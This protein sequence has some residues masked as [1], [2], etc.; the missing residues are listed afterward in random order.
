MSEELHYL[1]KYLLQFSRGNSLLGDLEILCRFSA[2]RKN[3][4]ELGTAYGLGAMMLLSDCSGNVTTITALYSPTGASI[5]N[6]GGWVAAVSSATRVT[7]THT[8][9]KYMTDFMAL[10]VNGNDVLT[11][12]IVDVSGISTSNY[13]VYQ[14]LSSGTPIN[15]IISGITAVKA[16]FAG[17]GSGDFYIVYFRIG[18]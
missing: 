9:A 5:N 18:Q 11:R 2:N 12:S 8:Q 4:V 16:G 3:I 15:F 10:G 7:V 17:A 14:T 1:D 6:T 13:T